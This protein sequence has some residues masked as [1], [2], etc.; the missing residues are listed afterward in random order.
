MAEADDQEKTEDPSHRRMEKALE[1]GQTLTSKEMFVFT[2]M[3]TGVVLIFGLGAM[4]SRLLDKWRGYFRFDA[5]QELI[6]QIFYRLSS[7]MTDF[8]ILAL[9][10]AVPILFVALATQAVVGGLHFIPSNLQFKG[11]RINPIAGFKRMFSLQSLVELAKALLKVGSLGAVS[12][13]LLWQMLPDTLLLVRASL[14]SSIWRISQDFRVLMIAALVILAVIAAL[15]YA[16]SRHSHMQKLRMSKQDLKDEHKES[17]GSPEVKSR[18]R[19]LQIESSRRAAKAA[20]AVEN[21]A[22]ATA[23]IT[24]PT[25]F[26]VALRYMPGDSGAPK[27]IAM[28]RGKLAERIIEKGGEAGITV[29]RSPVLARAIF[30]TSDIGQEISDRLYNSVAIVLAY[31]YRLDRGETVSEPDVEVPRDLIFNEDGRPTFETED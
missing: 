27:V 20:T 22:E 21:I 28:G 23:I 3:F 13:I 18:I 16:Y 6:D 26:A 19:R 17:E 11:N 30:F 9:A 1:E 7:A 29:F 14:S 4:I 10:I 8:L 31:I 15:D 25:H 12:G 2:S 24:N 5:S